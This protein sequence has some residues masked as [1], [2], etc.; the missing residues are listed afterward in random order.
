MLYRVRARAELKEGSAY[1]DSPWR[2]LCA[3][4]ATLAD[5]VVHVA[6]LDAQQG[7]GEIHATGEIN[8]DSKEF[9]LDSHGSGIELAQVAAMHQHRVEATGK[10]NFTLAGSG[11]FDDPHLNAH[12]AFSDLAWSGEPL[13]P[14]EITAHSANRSVT[15]EASTRVETASM[16]LHGETALTGDYQT[17]AHLDYSE[18]NIAALLAM[19]HS[20]GA[21]NGDSA[22]AGS[23]TTRK[24]VGPHRSKCAA[25]HEAQADLAVTI[26]GV[27][28]K[29]DNGRHANL[30]NSRVTL[31]PGAHHR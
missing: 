4:C 12:A 26:A 31:N 27:H 19:A 28:L 10:L 3:A 11:S 13:G 18:F 25:T 16:S 8:I 9:K 21:S 30:T 22:L 15:Y 29:S 23:V 1:M 2:A 14:L 24:A 20:R 7:A 6:A 17:K 5:Q